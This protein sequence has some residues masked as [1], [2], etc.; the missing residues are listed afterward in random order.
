MKKIIE[1]LIGCFLTAGI[2]MLPYASIHAQN[3]N[4]QQVTVNEGTSQADRGT[5]TSAEG[6]GEIGVRFMLTFTS[7]QLSDAGGGKIEGEFTFGYGFGALLGYNFTNHIGM[8]GEIIYNS[9]AQKYKYQD[10]DNKITLRYLNIPLLLSLNTDKSKMINLN[11]VVGPQ[12]GINVGSDISSSG[13]NDVDTV[14][15]VLAVKRGDLGFVYGAG[16]QFGGNIKFDLGFRG[17][18]GLVD[19]SDKSNS[20]TT[21][22]YYILDRAHVKTYSVYAGVSFLF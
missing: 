8:D 10:F 6:S 19:I 3:Q 5:T 20:T 15:A 21:S 7:F 18:Y 17:V 9:I 11:F 16:L 4:N 14:N 12:I 22:D 2:L 1:K 13:G